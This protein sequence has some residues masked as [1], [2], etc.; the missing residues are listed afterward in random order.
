MVK[1]SRRLYYLGVGEEHVL[2]FHQS[3]KEY[4]IWEKDPMNDTNSK[5]R[6]WEDKV[7]IGL[8]KLNTFTHV[9]YMDHAEKSVEVSLADAE[10]IFNQLKDISDLSHEMALRYMGIYSFKQEIKELLNGDYVF[11][12]TETT[13][14]TGNDEIVQLG[15][16]DGSSREL[17]SGMFKPSQPMHWAAAKTT[18]ITDKMLENQP[19]FAEQIDKI[20]NV[21][22]GRKIIAYNKE[23]DERLFYQTARRYNLLNPEVNQ[24]FKGSLCAMKLYSQY[25]GLP[26]S[27]FISMQE[28]CLCEGI[29]VI[30]DHRAVSDCV[31]MVQLLKVIS[32]MS[33]LPD[34]ERLKQVLPEKKLFTLSQLEKSKNRKKESQR[35]YSPTYL[36]M[37]ND[38]KSIEEM[39]EIRG[40]K[41][42][43]VEGNLIDAYRDGAD[44]NIDLLIQK[45]YES[46]ILKIANSGKWD[47]KLKSM[48]MQLPEE[49]TYSTIRAVLAK[50]SRSKTYKPLDNVVNKAESQQKE[51]LQQGSF[52]KNLDDKFR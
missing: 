38:G 25:Y 26:S 29:N 36:D 33:R 6:E 27:F 10:T 24:A 42:S 11:L 45:E 30:Q 14:L 21:I 1:I 22:G 51:M 4:Y 8:C 17:F 49:C 20:M 52:R 34:M 3:G 15:I 46:T 5:I 12:D 35:K 19:R 13:G 28:A 32:D 18:G 23:F 50:R 44:I 47:W 37:Y 16:I 7:E 39:A 31:M 48:K 9:Y 40:V 43:T 41:I 2:S